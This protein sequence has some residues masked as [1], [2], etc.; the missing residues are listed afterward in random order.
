MQIAIDS[1]KRVFDVDTTAE[2]ARIR[3]EID[4][5]GNGYPLF[6]SR[7]RKGFNQD[8]INKDLIC[9][10]NIVSTARATEVHFSRETPMSYFYRHIPIPNNRDRKN[11]KVE[12]FIDKYMREFRM[13]KNDRMTTDLDENTTEDI[14][15][16]SDFDQ[17]IADIKKIYISKNYLALYS[18]LIGRVFFI[19]EGQKRSSAKIKEKTVMHKNRSLFI[20]ILYEV[21]KDALVACF[22]PPKNT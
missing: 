7:I 8:A 10:M 16:R 18:W 11:E 2:I 5:K 9:P 1:S 12:Q 6:W 13:K 22:T 21:N 17:L 14:L 19:T 3:K 15:L 4:V 20:K